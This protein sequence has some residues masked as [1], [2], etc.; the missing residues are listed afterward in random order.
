MLMNQLSIWKPNEQTTLI[1]F[2]VETTQSHVL[3][4]SK[5]RLS[6]GWWCKCHHLIACM[7]PHETHKYI[8]LPILLDQ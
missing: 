1:E 8:P 2:R 5:I 7:G 3:I 6:G 4:A